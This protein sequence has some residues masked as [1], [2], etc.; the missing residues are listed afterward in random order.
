MDDVGESITPNGTNAK[1]ITKVS[2]TVFKINFVNQKYMIV[3]LKPHY[4]SFT[5]FLQ[6]LLVTI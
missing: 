6:N 4:V 1:K 2:Q 5:T 3:Q